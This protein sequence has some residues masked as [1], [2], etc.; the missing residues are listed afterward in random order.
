MVYRPASRRKELGELGTVPKGLSTFTPVVPGRGQWPLLQEPSGVWSGT[1]PKGLS[2]F[3][4]GRP[5]SRPM[6]APTGTVGDCP[7]FNPKK[8]RAIA[9][10]DSCLIP[11]G[12]LLGVSGSF[13]GILGGEIFV[14]EVT[15]NRFVID[16]PCMNVQT[17]RKVRIAPERILPAEI[18]QLLDER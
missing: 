17:I 12:G 9:R 18:R 1:V 8:G 10:P 15:S 4:P 5:R 16:M 11:P 3:Y 2:P 14:T 13:E 6:A 7:L